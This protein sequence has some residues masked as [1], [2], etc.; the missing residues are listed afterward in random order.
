V[1]E[2]NPPEVLAYIFYETCDIKEMFFFIK[3]HEINKI[4]KEYFMKIENN[5][6]IFS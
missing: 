3:S 5:L 1:Q 2:D 4:L 6:D